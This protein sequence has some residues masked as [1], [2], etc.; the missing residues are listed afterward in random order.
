M[1][2][3]FNLKA[4]IDR[5]SGFADCYDKYRPA[6]PTIVRDILLSY[7]G[8]KPSVVIDL[9][10]GTGLSTFLW[11]GYSEKIIGLEPNADM[12]TKASA[13]L[14]E[15]DKS[16]NISFQEGY[17]HNICVESGSADIVTCSQAFHWMEPKSTLEEV[18]RVL[19]KGGIFAAYD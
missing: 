1:G 4:N 6:A 15:M 14:L 10:S 8:K 11:R 9:G 16:C 12:R 18:D 13:K 17:C 5:F 7:L 19:S 3:N 2:N